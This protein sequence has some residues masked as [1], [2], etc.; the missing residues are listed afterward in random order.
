MKKCPYCAEMIQEDAKLCRFCNTDLITGSPRSLPPTNES[1]R[2]SDQQILPPYSEGLGCL[3]ALIPGLGQMAIGKGG[4]GAAMLIG[5][6]LLGAVSY[7]VLYAIF[8][9]W[10]YSDY[11]NSTKR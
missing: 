9:G 2:L 3:T 11:K 6:I 7:G 4:K 1:K 10:S 5:A 8:M